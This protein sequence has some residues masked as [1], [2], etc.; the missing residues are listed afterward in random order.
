MR[1]LKSVIEIPFLCFVFWSLSGCELVTL[2]MEEAIDCVFRMSA[3]L[4]ERS[5]E[6]ATV[7][8]FYDQKLVASVNNTPNEHHFEYYFTIT[9]DIPPGLE[10]NV[11]DRT[12]FF[13]GIPSEEGRYNFNVHVDIEYTGDPEDE[14]YCFKDPSLTRTYVIEVVRASSQQELL[15]P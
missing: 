4:D 6:K 12:I 14:R 2:A 5:L 13:R 9:G 7:G 15:G 1:I 8:V 3:Q 11:S 10:A